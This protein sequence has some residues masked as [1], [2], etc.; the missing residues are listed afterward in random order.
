M[1]EGRGSDKGRMK[2]RESSGGGGSRWRGSGC[3]GCGS[4]TVAATSTS[5]ALQ[6]WGAASSSPPWLRVASSSSLLATATTEEAGSTAAMTEVAGST[7][8]NDWGG[9]IRR[10]DD[11]SSMAAATTTTT[12]AG[13]LQPPPLYHLATAVWASAGGGHSGLCLRENGMKANAMHETCRDGGATAR[14]A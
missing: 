12:T 7:T 11:C 5:V 9:R 1:S 6:R 8:A 14:Q 13:F 4:V 3:Q 2:G 10:P